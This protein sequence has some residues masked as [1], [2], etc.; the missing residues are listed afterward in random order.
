MHAVS[1]ERRVDD[2]PNVGDLHRGVVV[3][4]ERDRSSASCRPRAE[5]GW[6]DADGVFA[7]RVVWLNRQISL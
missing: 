3:L 6:C 5:R 2:G 1:A 7:G 4:C